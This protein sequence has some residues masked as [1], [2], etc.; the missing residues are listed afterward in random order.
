MNIFS[1]VP[2]FF[3]LLAT[4]VCESGD[5]KSMIGPG[6]PKSALAAVTIGSRRSSA[7]SS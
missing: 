1:N 2:F 3:C 4:S 6:D 7:C 5:W